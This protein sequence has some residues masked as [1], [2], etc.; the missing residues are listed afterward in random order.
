MTLP[1][2]HAALLF[3]DPQ[4]DFLD[5]ASVV[6]DVV[7]EE[8]ERVGVLGNL[9][10]LR[11]AALRAG[12]PVFYSP[13]SYTDNEYSDWGHLNPLD[14]LMFSRRLF[15]ATKPGSEFHPSLR[16]TK[17][18]T[19]LSATRRCRASGAP[20]S[21]SSCASATSRRSSSPGC[22]RT[23]AWSPTCA[24][25]P[26]TG[27]TCTSSVTGPLAPVAQRPM[28]HRSTSASSPRRS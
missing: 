13:H 9:V 6:W 8:V 26:K 18:V 23:C 27:S 19:V 25:P 11:E 28:R 17:G 4:I 21:R 1:L 14:N 7:G 5:P 16:P 2:E 15:D 20:I 10:R 24:T 3:I 22:P 12:L